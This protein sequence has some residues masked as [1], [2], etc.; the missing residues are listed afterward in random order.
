MVIG[1]A[2][3]V[4]CTPVD[5]LELRFT[6][7]PHRAATTDVRVFL[8]GGPDTESPGCAAID[9][10]GL[11]F[12]DAAQRTGLQPAQ[13]QGGA[14]R[15]P[16]A[17]LGDVAVGLYTVAIEAWGPPCEVLEGDRCSRLA[18]ADP[19]V[20]RAYYC[21]VFELG[22]RRLTGTAN[23]DSFADIGAEMQKPT[24]A[25]Y[26]QT[27]PLLIADGLNAPVP[28][29]VKLLTSIGDEQND[30]KVHFSVESGRAIMEESQ[31]ILTARV[32]NDKGIASSTVRALPGASATDDGSV[33]VAAYAPGYENS[34]LRFFSKSLPGVSI[35]I[36]QIIVP[37]AQATMD[38]LDEHTLPAV[39]HDLN[40]DGLLDVITIAGGDDYQL[41]IH[42]GG[43]TGVH[44]SLPQPSQARTLTVARLTANVPSVVVSSADPGSTRTSTIIDGN[45]DEL[46]VVNNP[47]Y[48]VWSGLD[49]P[50]AQV[51]LTD[52]AHVI[53]HVDGTPLT[54]VTIAMDAAD[55]DGDN[56]DEIAASRCSYLFEGRGSPSFVRCTGNLSAENDSEI[57]V[58]A[59][60]S[61]RD[62]TLKAVLKVIAGNKGGYREVRFTDLN[63][64]GS[65]D[66]VFTS[67]INVHGACGRRFQGADGFGFS[68]ASG[69]ETAGNSGSYAV[70]VGN[71]DNKKGADVVVSSTI[72]SDSPLSR[73]SLFGGGS[74][75][76]FSAGPVFESGPKSRS[77]L[78]STRAADVNGDGRDDIL[79]LHRETRSIQVWLGGGNLDFT[80]G[81]RIDLPSGFVGE[82]A[83]ERQGD[84]VVAATVSPN[85]NAI[86]RIQF[87]PR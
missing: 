29:S 15:D 11:P 4:S 67:N 18:V 6:S 61:D 72:K 52:P 34:P 59:P 35:Q 39:L 23:L 1:V 68:Q 83:V 14:L 21:N 8:F 69:F 2:G 84:I 25:K 53:T 10:R 76:A 42:Y 37:R 64:D 36:E 13:T 26:S 85:D 40:S 51:V 43:E 82:L 30:I 70:A 45:P 57:A 66:L 16:V 47:K 31:P 3:A 74:C 54:K 48:S 28:F 46:R 49:Q 5:Q 60:I 20:L 22:D 65:T 71:F 79:V 73:F 55:L 32:V 33:V 50:A 78:I 58:L 17:E 38:R 81:P 44:T 12:G 75:D 24:D 7:Q 80:A 56:I 87:V 62:L 77:Y 63:D 9:P 86:F 41:L 19:T 27:D